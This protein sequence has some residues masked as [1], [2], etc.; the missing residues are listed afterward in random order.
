MSQI[1]KN[2]ELF[3]K[4]FEMNNNEMLE[5]FFRSDITEKELSEIKINKIVEGDEPTKIV[6]FNGRKMVITPMTVNVFYENG[7]LAF[8]S[9]FEEYMN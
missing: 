3:N 9:T 2:I 7:Q 1:S 4:L 8:T 6:L 5:Q